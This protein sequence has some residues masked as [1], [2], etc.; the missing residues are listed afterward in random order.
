MRKGDVETSLD[1]WRIG[2]WVLSDD[3]WVLELLERTLEGNCYDL[4]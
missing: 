2:T 3:V 1:A 4:S